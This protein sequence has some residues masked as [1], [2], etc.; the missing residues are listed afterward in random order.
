MWMYKQVEGA[1]L[2]GPPSISSLSDSMSDGEQKFQSALSESSPS[3]AFQDEIF[4]PTVP[5]P[6]LLPPS[7]KFL[8]A[9]SA[10][11]SQVWEEV[12]SAALKLSE[13]EPILAPMLTTTII[14]QPSFSA[15][16][17]YHLATLI[18]T[19]TI[20]ADLWRDVI[21]D[22]TAREPEINMLIEADLVAVMERDP[23]CDNYLHV[24]LDFK[25]FLGLSLH[26]V[27]HWLW[28]QNRRGLA[29]NLQSRISQ[30]FA[31]DIHPAAQIGK[32]VLMDHAT[33]IVIGE[34]AV[35][36]DGCSLLHGVTLGGTGKEKG[37]RHP[38]LGKNVLIGTGVS[39]L[40]NITIGDGAKIGA[41]SV[42][43]KSIP[44]G[45][46]AVGVPAKI[47]GKSIEVN[48]AHSMDNTMATVFWEYHI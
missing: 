22:A 44:P 14:K 10:H 40:G 21:V 8:K 29:Y 33:G 1:G 32:S 30:V 34:T 38:K 39:V 12:R 5:A 45:A 26:R 37:D 23:A 3:S 15:A 11:R 47:V 43:L 16:L 48:P 17:A 9:A 4:L 41:G 28:N 31:I 13:E 24:F 42:V 2:H 6:S 19:P 20:S 36:G 35:V 18:E 25:G 46:T 27:S 7:N